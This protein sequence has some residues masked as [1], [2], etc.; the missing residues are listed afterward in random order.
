[1]PISIFLPT[2]ALE[3]TPG[4]T[5]FLGDEPEIVEAQREQLVAGY[6]D[7]LEKLTGL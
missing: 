1:M 4:D 5:L 2:L 6:P 3:A 7:A